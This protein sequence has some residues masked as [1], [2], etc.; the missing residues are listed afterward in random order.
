MINAQTEI[1]SHVLISHMF[2]KC[3]LSYVIH[4]VDWAAIVRLFWSFSFLSWIAPYSD[5]LYEITIFHYF[6][7]IS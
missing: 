6:H 4:G 2:T 3:A 1:G 7:V 5:C